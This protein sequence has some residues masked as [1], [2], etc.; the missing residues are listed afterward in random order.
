MASFYTLPDMSFYKIPDHTKLSLFTP[1]YYNI[2]Y[3]IIPR[4]PCNTM[5]YH[6]IPC[7]TMLYHAI[8]LPYHTISHHHTYA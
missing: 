6:A 2:T 5:P 8:T 4:M 3:H 7:H 1:E